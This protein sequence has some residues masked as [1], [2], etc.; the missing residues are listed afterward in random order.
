MAETV[1]PF[2]IARR[3]NDFL[4]C[5]QGTARSTTLARAKSFN[6][7]PNYNK[8]KSNNARN[9]D[10]ESVSIWEFFTTDVESIE[11]VCAVCAVFEQVFFAL[12]KFLAAFVFSETVAAAAYA[13]CLNGEDKVV[14]V[15]TV[16]ERHKALLA[17]KTLVDEKVFLIVPHGITE[18]DRLDSPAVAFKL[19]DDHP[20]E[21]L[22]VDGIV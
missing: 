11:S 14:V 7:S 22:F 12:G 13:G 16:E 10:R 1:A 18:I 15:L 2:T 9:I 17:G 3:W 4:E 20:T 8:N 6:A 5:P 19:V 21:V